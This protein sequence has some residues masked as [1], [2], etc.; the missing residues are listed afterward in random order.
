MQ[1]PLRLIIVAIVLLLIGVILPF[2]MVL[3]LLESTLALNFISY[4]CSTA[5]LIL[6]FVGIAQY[7]R[8]RE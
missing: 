3:Q 2:L 4:G 7:T 8:R 6:G 5:G 1:N